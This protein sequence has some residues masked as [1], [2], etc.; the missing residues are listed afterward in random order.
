M[1]SSVS[2]A[3]P[4][5]SLLMMK[6]TSAGASGPSPTPTLLGPGLPRYAPEANVFGA[7]GLPK[8]NLQRLMDAQAPVTARRPLEKRPRRM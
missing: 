6:S 4:G 8:A 2:E 1:S 3:E 5:Q 7:D